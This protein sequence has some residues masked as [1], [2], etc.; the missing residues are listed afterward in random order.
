MFEESVQKKA[1]SVDKDGDA[2]YDVISAVQ[3]SI[4]GSDTDAALHYLARLIEAGDLPIIAR[5]LMVTAYEDIGLANPE[6]AARVL[7]AIQT[8]ERLG[9]PEGR[10]PLAT[11]TVELCLSAKSNTAY[12]ALD[13]AIQYV[14]HERAHEIPAHL[15]DSHYDGAKKLGHGVTYQYPHDATSGWVAQQYLPDDMEKQGTVFYKGKQAG[16]EKRLVMTYEKLRQLK[17]NKH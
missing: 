5:R 3:K 12:K 11:I 1:L 8:V 10:I 17:Q 2:H 6:L 7:P 15:K 9:L 16:E 13:A 14:Q 4:R